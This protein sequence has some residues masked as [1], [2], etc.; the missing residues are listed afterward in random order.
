MTMAFQCVADV[1]GDRVGLERGDRSGQH[2]HLVPLDQLEGLRARSRRLPGRV[3]EGDLDLASGQHAAALLQRELE[4][5][6]PSGG[7]TRRSVRSEWSGRRAARVPAPTP[8]PPRASRTTWT[9]RGRG[10]DVTWRAPLAAGLWRTWPAMSTDLRPSG[11]FCAILPGGGREAG[12]QRCRERSPSCRDCSPVTGKSD[13]PAD[14]H[15]VVDAVVKVFGGVRGPFSMLLHSPKLGGAGARP[16]HVL[17]RRGRDRAESQI[18]RHPGRGARARS[19]LRVG[20]AG[21]RRAPQRRERRDHRSAPGQG[22]RRQA[23]PGRARDRDLRPSAHA[24]ESRRPGRLRRAQEAPQRPVARRAARRPRTTSRS[25]PGSS[26]RSRSRRPPTATSCRCFSTVR[27]PEM[28]PRPST[29]GTPRGNPEARLDFPGG[30][31]DGSARRSSSPT[32]PSGRW[33]WA[34]RSRTWLRI[35]VGARALAHSSCRAGRHFPRAASC[36]RSTTT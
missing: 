26:T 36:P 10:R 20:G 17:S 7:R 8:L 6:P 31:S 27:A 11:P 28:A 4:L 3:A 30:R 5:L 14:Q 29:L 1:V 33:R 12:Q 16:R 19:R 2:V 25:C 35:T 23:A 18:G 22:R 21:R 34:E 15:A 9:R 13:V 24:D 32:I